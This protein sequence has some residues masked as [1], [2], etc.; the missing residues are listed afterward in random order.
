MKIQ[1]ADE[2]RQGFIRYF[3]SHGHHAVP[4]RR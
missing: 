3:G 1:T 4:V 2:L